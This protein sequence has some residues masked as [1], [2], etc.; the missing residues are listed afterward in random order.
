MIW[1]WKSH[2]ALISMFPPIW[3]TDMHH[4]LD[5]SYILVTASVLRI[6]VTLMLS[7]C[8][9]LFVTTMSSWNYVITMSSPICKIQTCITFLMHLTSLSVV[10]STAFALNVSSSPAPFA[11]TIVIISILSLCKSNVNVILVQIKYM[12]SKCLS[13]ISRPGEVLQSTRSQDP[14]HCPL[15]QA[16]GSEKR[17][18]VQD[19]QPITFLEAD[20]RC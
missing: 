5:A 7:L 17:A 12:Q 20:A 14:S 18:K 3:K 1:L 2:W 13:L 9:H 15:H 19:G 6:A 8:H 11:W 4:F 16:A 10:L